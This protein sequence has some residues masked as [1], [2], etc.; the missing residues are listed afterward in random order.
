MKQVHLR[1]DATILLRRVSPNPLGGGYVRLP[2][3]SSLV[4]LDSEVL[5]KLQQTQEKENLDISDAVAHICL[6]ELERTVGLAPETFH[7]ED[8]VGTMKKD[9]DG[10][11]EPWVVEVTGPGL[12]HPVTVMLDPISV[13]FP[14]GYT[15]DWPEEAF[16]T[17]QAAILFVQNAP[18]EEIK[19]SE[20]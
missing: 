12:P 11:R 18:E 3:G 14:S 16:T 5:T 8:L 15:E 19:G 6:R 7:T 20:E 4:E 9:E 2:D 13:W 1:R 17:I 10:R